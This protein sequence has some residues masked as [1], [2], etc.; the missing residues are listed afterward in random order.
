MDVC[1][2][3]IGAGGYADNEVGAAAATGDGDIMMR[4]LPSFLAVEYLRSGSPPDEAAHRALHRIKKFHPNYYGAVIVLKKNGEYG[5]ACNG[6][7]EFPFYVAKND[8]GVERHT[9]ICL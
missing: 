5:V 9:I 4:F 6:M 3:L 1:K 2:I 7:D 8:S